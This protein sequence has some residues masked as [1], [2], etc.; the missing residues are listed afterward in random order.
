VDF[1]SEAA[2]WLPATDFF[3]LPS[4]WEGQPLVLLEAMRA[5]IPAVTWTTVGAELLPTS[6]HVASPDDGATRVRMWLETPE[7][8]SIDIE[9]QRKIA[10]GHDLIIAISWYHSLYYSY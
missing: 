2:A 1:V 9:T 10:A 7:T 8:A 4:R 5:G 6:G 3:V